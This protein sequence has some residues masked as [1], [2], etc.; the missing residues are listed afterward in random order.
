MNHRTTIRDVAREAG[1]SISTVS[2]YFNHP[3]ALDEKT[4][5]QVASAI[6]KT[7]YIPSLAAQSLKNQQSRM[8]L[9][10]VPDISN[11]F[12]S[13]LTK[14]LQRLAEESGYAVVTSDTDE[15]FTRELSALS[16]ARV[17]YASGVLAA[18]VSPSQEVVKALSTLG[19]PVVGLNAYP[20][21]EA[22]D[23]VRVHSQGGTNLAVKHL[24]SLGHREIAFAGGKPGTFIAQSR[25]DGYLCEMKQAGLPVNDHLMMEAGF[26]QADGFHAG[27]YFAKQNQMPTAICCANDLIAFGVLS[28]LHDLGIRVPQVVSVTGMDDTMY[29]SISSPRLTTVKNDP[30]LFARAGFRLLM[31]RITGS[32]TGMPR[33]V[34]IPNELIIRESTA[35]SRTERAKE[36]Y[37]LPPEEKE[38]I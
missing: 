2:R 11:P 24:I 18:S 13:K 4:L 29:A 17:I 20:S 23:V 38:F 8:L 6:K 5:Q 16:M 34:E 7:G 32:Y 9:L 3:E 12:Y 35:I 28:A 15:S 14:E 37:N 10:Y 27:A 31:E 19:I 36:Q 33:T 21:N 1:I 22:F 25:R 30:L 26:T